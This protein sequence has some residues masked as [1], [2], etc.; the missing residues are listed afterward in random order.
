[1]ATFQS[2][3]NTSIMT[4]APRHRLGVANGMLGMTRTLGQLTGVALLG[5]FFSVRLQHYGGKAV[6][7]TAASGGT[8]VRALHDQFH[9][10][11]ALVG[12]G[13]LVALR[14]ARREWKLKQ[15]EGRAKQHR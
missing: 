2:P 13:A 14:Q 11:A 3:N 7:V 4:A 5:T 6:D 10:A 15:L 9:L 12:I 1:M 8:I